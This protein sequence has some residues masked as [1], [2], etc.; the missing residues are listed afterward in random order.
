ML[1]T[2]KTVGGLM[3]T[4]LMSATLGLGLTACSDQQQDEE[5]PEASTQ[6]AAAPEEPAEPEEP[7]APT[8]ALEEPPPPAPEAAL[9]PAPAPAP[10]P[11]APTGG[12]ADTARVVRY[13]TEDDTPIMGTASDSGQA[14][15][16]LNKG[17]RVMVI[18]DGG[19]GRISDNMFIK[20]DRLSAKA[21]ARNRHP[22]VW[23]P[24]SN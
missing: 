3:R 19:W 4:A 8:E 13:I 1:M 23:N 5:K 18:E 14:V 6:E 10:E 15:G 9:A 12:E 24:P 17:D 22:A 20:A 16:K 11:A 2:V 7:A 21:V